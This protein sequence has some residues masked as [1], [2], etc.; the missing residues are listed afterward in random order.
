M[1]Y[2]QFLA[3]WYN[4]VFIAAAFIGLVY[5][6]WARARGSPAFRSAIVLFTIALVGL[7]WNGAIHDLGLGSPAPRFPLVLLV[8]VGAGL[9]MSRLVGGLRDR[10]FRP[11]GG[12]RFNRPGHEGVEA[13]IVTRNAGPEP[14]SGR[15]QWQDGDGVLHIVHVHT[16]GEV[17]GFGCRVRLGDFDADAA[18]Y[19][20]S[21]AARRQ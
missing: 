13:R 2:F 12:V 16:H 15:A 18:S 6:G 20:A 4:A 9:L 7:T 21:P 8:A 14:G 3:E 1:T 17:L 19:L 11:I 10:Y 5:I